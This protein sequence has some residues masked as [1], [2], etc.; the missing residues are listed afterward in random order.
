MRVPLIAATVVAALI[1]GGP[2]GAGT[3]KVLVGEQT[4]PPAGTPEGT[5]LNAFFP[6]SLTVAAGDKVVFQSRGF[7][8]VAYLAGGK[9]APLILPDP[10]KSLYK[11]IAGSD[12][13]PFFFDG[14]PKFV[15]NGQAFAPYG[16]NIV[17][18]K[19]L[20]SGVIVPGRNGK[21]VTA[22]FTLAKPGAY[23]FLCTVHP[24]MKAKID[25]KPAGAEVPSQAQVDATAKQQTDAAWAKAKP[26]AA[27]KVAAN[28][29]LA[30]VGST[31]TILGFV[32]KQLKVKAGTA[33]TFIVKSP[34]EVHNIAFGPP[35]YLEKLSKQTD[36]FPMGPN[37]PNQATPF[38]IYGSEPRGAYTYDGANHGNG[39]LMTPL[40]DGRPGGL[41]DVARVT[42]TKPG[43]FKYICFL[44][45]PDMK[46]EI[47]V[48]Q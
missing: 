28:T 24:G 46:G 16:G 29:V 42:F 2:A 40:G 26:L 13:N 5:T 9:P 30:G 7:H 25:V 45:G 31:T 11:D 35:K 20:S 22:T 4:K 48:T 41:P 34:S 44:H 32:P 8:T 17:S 37:A 47:V 15:Y 10:A 12:G 1:A 19:P 14:M 6:R 33:V 23:Q 21:P 39:L 27:T 36:L 18:G 3:F 43:T 38:Y